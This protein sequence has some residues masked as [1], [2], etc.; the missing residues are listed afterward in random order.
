V[1]KTVGQKAMDFDN[2]L[3]AWESGWMVRRALLILPGREMCSNDLEGL[4]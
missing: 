4:R 2:W 3:S 1:G